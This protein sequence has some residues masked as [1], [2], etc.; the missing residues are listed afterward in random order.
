M[1]RKCF[2]VLMILP[3]LAASF[4]WGACPAGQREDA[5]L[6]RRSAE[7]LR[8]A[9]P[10]F[11]FSLVNEEGC[12]I[13]RHAKGP[14]VMLHDGVQRSD[15]ALQDNPSVVDS[16]TPVYPLGH[17][18]RYPAQGQDPGRA[19]N[20]SL[21]KA[22]YGE[23]RQEVEAQLVDVPFLGGT[24]RFSS[25]HG[26]AKAL[27]RVAQ[28]LAAY[29]QENPKDAA[30]L[31]PVAGHY[32]WRT[33]AGTGRLSAH[34]FGIAVDLNSQKGLYW[35]WKPGAPLLESTRQSYPQA[36]V[37]IFESEGFVWGGKWA[38]FDFMH[39]EYR[40]EI[41]IFAQRYGKVR[42]APPEPAK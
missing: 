37:D 8:Q 39:F 12:F 2:G 28:R 4:S 18:G 31:K 20:V 19:R 10:E 26:A 36:V 25:R 6:V 15:E 13:L 14:A 30:W 24:V 7:I 41:L 33:I 29:M 11:P 21:L 35:Q 22:L 5:V 17:E 1:R 16:F 23:T 40:P 9:Y 42:Q 32:Y 3:L 27:E 38:H 34:S